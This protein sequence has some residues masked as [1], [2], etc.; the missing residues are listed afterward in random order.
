MLTAPWDGNVEYST[1]W[2]SPGCLKYWL[3]VLKPIDVIGMHVGIT[4]STWLIY[5]AFW[6]NSVGGKLIKH[7]SKT[8]CCSPLVL[9]QKVQIVV[10]KTWFVWWNVFYSFWSWFTKAR[11]KEPG[12][13]GRRCTGGVDAFK[14]LWGRWRQLKS[15]IGTGHGGDI[16]TTTYWVW[17]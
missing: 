13:E 12:V 17:V 1:L 16:S 8:H 4:V 7:G 6:C 15:V 5:R 2:Y 11:R 9:G 3:R 14:L 10:L